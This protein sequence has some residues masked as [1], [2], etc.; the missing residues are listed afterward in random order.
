MLILLSLTTTALVMSKIS[1]EVSTVFGLL[2]G[3][4]L[5][6]SW[7]FYDISR[8]AFNPFP[9]VFLSFLLLFFLCDVLSGQTKKYFLAA[10]PVG[11]AFHTDLASAI[12]IS[13]FFILVSSALLVKRRINFSHVLGALT[14][15]GVFLVP[16]LISELKTNFSQ[17][18]TLIREF[19]NPSGIFSKSK[20]PIISQTYLHTVARSTFRQIPELGIFIFSLA[21]ITFF[22]RASTTPTNSHRFSRNFIF[23][24]LTLFV[25]SWAFFAT[26]FG[27]RDWQ[28]AFLSPLILVS[29]L[30]A[31][32]H[33]SRPL[34]IVIYSLS[35]ISHLF[36]FVTR[37]QQNLYPTADPSLLTN[38]IKAID[39]VYQKSNSQ[40]FSVYSYLPSV[41][42]YPYQ[43]LF[44]W[45]GLKKYGFLPC[46]Y[47]SFPNSPKLFLPDSRPYLI[48][49]KP[50]TNT[51]FLIIEPDVNATNRITWLTAI[52]ENTALIEEVHIGQITV[53]KRLMLNFLKPGSN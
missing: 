8:Y 16:H 30:L 31:L 7:W 26:N 14:I 9:L 37:Y 32:T 20:I 1:R 52:T 5:Q 51:R 19:N 46:E 38:E 22:T 40:G 34:A 53:Q 43:Y 33:I 25:T 42:D 18:H 21:I 36:I 4:T 24:A 6:T 11:L 29:L 44:W 10:I 17:T 23:L 27:W 15:V 3:A 48:P 45:H 13:L 49:Q 2:V 28:T 41:F 39:W 12:A 50:C 35:L 47:S